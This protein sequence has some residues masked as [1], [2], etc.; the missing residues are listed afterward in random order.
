MSRSAGRP[1]A[2]RVEGVHRR[3]G[4]VRVLEGVDLTVD[5]DEV[6]ALVGENGAGKTTL[7]RCIA[8]AIAPDEGVVEVAGRA[9]EGSGVPRSDGLEV[10]WQDLALCDNLD[11]VDNLFLGRE[12]AWLPST[13]DAE[14]R[15][16]TLLARLGVVLPDLTRPVASLSGGQRQSVALARTL[17]GRPTLLV[18]DEP[19]GALDSG[20]VGAVEALISHMRTQDAAILL[21]SHDLDLVARVADR[22]L[23]LRDGA[24]AADLRRPDLTPPRIR[25][26]VAGMADDG[27]ARQQL[28]ALRSLVDQLAKV[29]PGDVLPLIVTA[30]GVALEQPR[31]ALH[32]IGP[33]G[34]TLQLAAGFG[35]DG[36]LHDALAALP[37]GSAHPLAQAVRTRDGVTVADLRG[38]ADPAAAALPAVGYRSTWSVPLVAGAEVL[39]TLSGFAA[40]IGPMTAGAMELA[41]L[42]ASHAA[43]AL[44]RD[45]FLTT[46]TRR[47]R[48]LE[49]IRQVLQELAGPQADDTGLGIAVDALRVGLAADDVALLDPSGAG[50]CRTDLLRADGGVSTWGDADGRTVM[51]VAVRDREHGRALVARWPAGVDPD[52]GSAELLVDGAR[53]LVLALQRQADAQAREEATALRRSNALQR[54]FLSRLSHELRT[55]LTAIHGYADTLRQPD[56]SWDDSSTGRFLDTIVR[57]SERLGH[58]VTDLLDASAV[59]AGVLHLQPDWCELGPVVDAAVACIPA[60]LRDR[61]DVLVDEDLSTVRVDH[62]RLQQVLVNLIGNALVHNAEDTR[63][64]VRVR[65]AG[66]GRLHVLVSDDGAGLPPAVQAGLFVA[67]V[68]GR[69]SGGGAGLGLSIADGIVRAH[70]GRITVRTGPDGTTFTVDLPVD[71]PP[72]DSPTWSPDVTPSAARADAG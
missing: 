30:V 28:H 52:E 24:I 49:T 66:R 7:V 9:V 22:V 17:I 12:P 1:P 47:N 15:A 33:D 55:P 63:V 62:D 36:P 21:V 46:V 37:V 50:R 31:L 71:G 35:L 42:Y 67:G 70:A 5:A 43:A 27:L 4:S 16:R 38:H 41:T 58:L 69:A 23:V 29:E 20:G 2:L 14:V 60:S 18:L 61:V 10:V 48:T 19:T 3:F 25:A 32:L 45:R 8:G 51:A 11:V 65:H 34:G 44:E 54:T 40:T 68:R 64:I 59:E 39:G 6:V 72:G 13:A 57:E 53:S 56:V 26:A